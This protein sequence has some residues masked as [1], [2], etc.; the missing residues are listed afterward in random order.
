MGNKGRNEEVNEDGFTYR[1]P[2]RCTMIKKKW[3]ITGKTVKMTT[4]LAL[5]THIYI[6]THIH[7]FY[8]AKLRPTTPEHIH[9]DT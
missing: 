2:S 8:N 9:K 1:P 4:N 7:T 3:K 6:H 5:Y